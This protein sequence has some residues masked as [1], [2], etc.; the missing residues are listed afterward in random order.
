[1]YKAWDRYASLDMIGI[2]EQKYYLWRKLWYSLAY[3]EREL[4]V[5]ISKEQLMEMK[6]HIY[7]ID[8]TRAA[9][10]ELETHHDV[11]AHLRTYAEAC[12]TAA[13]IIHL[14]ATSCYITDNADMIMMRDAIDL[15]KARL[16]ILIDDLCDFAETMAEVE[17]TGRTHFQPAQP[18]TV[19]KRATMWLQDFA[20]DLE[21]LKYQ[22][23]NL[24]P[25]GCKGAT[26]TCDSFLKLFDGNPVTVRQLDRNICHEFGFKD[27]VDVAGQ[28][29]SR[30]QDFYVLQVLSGIA[31]SA[32]K[33]ATD[34]RLMSG[35]GEIYEEF[36][37]TQVGSS[38]MPYKKNPMLCER[39]CGLSRLVICGLQNAAITASSQWLERSLDDSANRRI[40][41]PEMFM[42]TDA[43]I[44]TCIKVVEGLYVNDDVIDRNL[45]LQRPWAASEGILMTCVSRGGDRQKLH[46][47]LRQYATQHPNAMI[48]S[49]MKDPDFNITA[50]EVEKIVFQKNCGLADYQTEEYVNKVRVHELQKSAAGIPSRS[51]TDT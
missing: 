14:G 1:M 21:N 39:I 19:G 49:V 28:T 2:F 9:Q 30:K 6:S 43:V 13:P 12:P 29:Y 32:S 16:K 51:P 10:L 36:T 11:V 8:W 31:Q 42:G 17:I 26:G 46:E 34:I 35:L 4:G 27:P 40:L 25:L 48:G 24:R 38:A 22:Y 7:D 37:E 15:I 44:S 47:K 18:T 20:T 23:D 3:N 50:D 45:M 41:I 33:M 5:D